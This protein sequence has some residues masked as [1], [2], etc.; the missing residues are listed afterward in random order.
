MLKAVLDT[1]LATV[2]GQNNAAR[3]FN[4]LGAGWS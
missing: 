3:A 1:N 2:S 4:A